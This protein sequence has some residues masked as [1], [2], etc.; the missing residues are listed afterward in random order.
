[1]SIIDI[2]SKLSY[3]DIRKEE[4]LEKDIRKVIMSYGNTLTYAQTIG[5]LTM[6]I[7]YLIDDK[8][9]LTDDE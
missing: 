4:S 6:M 3:T 2:N 8:E 5:V 1:M 9:Y 7:N